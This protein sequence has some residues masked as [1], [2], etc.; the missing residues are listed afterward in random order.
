MR[1]NLSAN[2]LLALDWDRKT[3]RMVL[4]RARNDGVD[5]LKA[6]SV[7]IP[8]GVR[9][10]DAASLGAFVREAM[11]Q[12]RIGAKKA[13]LAIPRDHVVLNNLNIPPTPPEDLPAIVQFQVVKELPFPAEQATLDFA[14]TGEHDPKAPC[15]VLVA[16]VRNEDLTFYKSVA[17]AAGLDVERIGLRP[18]AN[19]IAVT[20]KAPELAAKALLLVEV[21]PH[22]TEINI[23]RQGQL[24][25]SRSANVTLPDQTEVESERFKDS[26]IVTTQ[27][28]E[29]KEDEAT[30]EAVSE[31][32]VEFVRSVEAYRATD[33]AFSLDH[34]VVC[35]AT[36][37][38]SYVVQALAA[39]YA[40]Q[41]E[42]FTPDRA[43]DLAPQRAR[44]LRGFNAALGLAI[45]HSRRG[46]SFIDFLHPKKP[47]SKR[48]LR[49]RKLPVAV[50]TAVLFIASGL[51][52]HYR[53][54]KPKTDEVT[55]LESRK[56]RLKKLEEPIL[57]F[58][59]QVEALEGW[60]ESEQRWPE[61]LTSVTEVFPV[62]TEGYVTRA[63]FEVVANG[64]SNLRDADARI[65]FRTVS[66]GMVNALA[67]KL[68]LSGF[69]TV[70]PGKETPSE[71][72]RDGYHY[73]TSVDFSIPRRKSDETAEISPAGGTAEPGEKKDLKPDAGDKSPTT[74]RPEPET[75]APKST[76]QGA[77]T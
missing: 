13:M 75:S 36:G 49:L 67:L 70:V 55:M 44:E 40:T 50:A 73:D 30:R 32:M 62:E 35:G 65:R 60:A 29:R 21:G 3:L 38:E 23:I 68:R 22:F 72:G 45:G 46:L 5:L 7:A 4:V 9:T 10:D 69:S 14:V 16:A 25:F 71:M 76:S 24:T 34:I 6:V 39:R 51:T 52:F 20:A 8:P 19:L 63:D 37:F 48:T 33:P 61:V 41:A 28:H 56:A 74:T 26:R 47:V 2:K 53:F 18:F 15:G 54:I 27:T 1:I 64:K 66:L 11:G 31:L 57:K 43:M 77:G 17:L 42:L 58:K 59:D 12:T